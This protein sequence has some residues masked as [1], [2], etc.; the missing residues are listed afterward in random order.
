[1]TGRTSTQG[2]RAG[3]RGRLRTITDRLSPA[4]TRD[5]ASAASKRR[6]RGAAEL[7]VLVVAG[8]LVA[9]VFFGTG[10]SRT[11]VDVADGL[12]WLSDDTNGQVIQVNP[13]TGKLEVKQTVGN[14]GDDL[15]IT[16]QYN[17]QLYVTDHTSGRLLAFDLT[18][19]LVSGQRRVSSGGV[20]NTLVN[21]S[22]VFLVD[23][24]LSTISAMDPQTT[25]AIGTIWIAP[26][27]L[28]DAA[29]DKD[30]TIWALEDNGV[31]HR[32]K[33]SEESLSFDD[34]DAEQVEG[35]GPGGVL[36]AHDKGV[37][38]FAPEQ[39]RIAQV[40]TGSDLDADAPKVLGKLFAP[41]SSPADLVPV[42]TENGFVVL[43]TPEG[44]LEID[45][46]TIDC[47]QPG[48]PEVFR[49]EVFVPCRGEG[50]VVRLGPDGKRSNDDIPTP[51]SRDPEL[52][53][54]D[55]NLIVNAPGASQGVVVHADGS[56]SAIVREDDDVAAQGMTPLSGQDST[57][58]G[59]FDDLLDGIADPPSNPPS[60]T[61][62][63]P[64]DPGPQPGNT[65]PPPGTGNNG[66]G[67]NGSGNNGSGTPGNNGIGNPGNH[68]T[69][70]TKNCTGLSTPGSP[71]PTDP[72]D[73]G[74]PGDGGS[75]GQPVTA[76]TDV[77]AT[78]MPEGQVQITW[79][80]S[81]FP[82]P[83]AF[84]VRTT[85]NKELGTF[86]GWVRQGFVNVPPGMPTSFTVTAVLGDREAVSFASN[87]V[88]TTARPGA[89][90][91]SGT[92][93]YQIDDSAL[94][95]KVTINWK[96]AAANGESVTGYA[97]TV[98]T[99]SGTKDTQLDGN[100]RSTSF[101]WSCDRKANPACTIGGD[102]N[103]SVTASSALGTGTTGLFSGKAPAV[104][105]APLPDNNTQVV[106]GSSPKTSQASETGA[107]EIT[108]KLSPPDKWKRFPGTCTYEYEGVRSSIACNAT[109]LRLT[110]SNGVIW[111]PDSGIVE[112]SVVFF[113]SNS[114]GTVRSA[115][116]TFTSEQTPRVR[117]T[118][119]PVDPDP[120]PSPTPS[121]I[122]QCQLP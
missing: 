78:A 65:S 13:A 55:D 118:P 109:S 31:L 36:V 15:S 35:S 27:G 85:E 28:A 60:N 40:G 1:M 52:V 111:E 19:I 46:S 117:P 16:D 45:M 106:D 7:S 39:G 32:L 116:F 5:T 68:D 9:G 90:V 81:G 8:S 14:P 3:W 82:K 58:P 56:T 62:P 38:V 97:V 63:T 21:D 93:A 18:S 61:P 96:E 34:E 107:G 91:V 101:E 24:E 103:A 73:T 2:A 43:V 6:S 30:G 17:G 100:A 80:H 79:R 64:T 77:V 54:D 112:H 69:D 22:G 83:D 44:L 89:P 119:G 71:S 122:P 59:G 113:A 29:V 114:G 26:A 67:N 33:W 11:A 99:P 102:Y 20:V 4:R 49:D 88:T 115:P 120:C 86:K 110:Y 48:T 105:P 108:L 25:D 47:G 70:C 121:P 104:P 98:Q 75:V 57:A 51:G 50:R 10:L 23:S 41:E 66:S 95:F 84:I 74:D 72:S 37:T 42:A 76:P 12:T 53:V 94:R 92:S 87:Q